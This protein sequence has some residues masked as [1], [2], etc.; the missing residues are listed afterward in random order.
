[1][2]FLT[3]QT[4]DSG[5]IFLAKLRELQQ[6]HKLLTKDE[7]AQ[8]VIRMDLEEGAEGLTI[9]TSPF[10]G[11][12]LRRLPSSRAQGTPIW[13]GVIGREVQVAFWSSIWQS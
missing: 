10:A 3:T 2:Q 8:L 4:S 6:A 9:A 13:G 11:S 12:R 7:R 5:S 1:M